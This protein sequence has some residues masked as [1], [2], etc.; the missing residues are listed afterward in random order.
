MTVP[1]QLKVMIVD[2]QQTTREISAVML[3]ANGYRVTTCTDCA[4][5]LQRLVSD[6]HDALLVNL[7]MPGM[8]RH[9]FLRALNDLPLERP[10]VKLGMASKMASDGVSLRPELGL[11]HVVWKPFRGSELRQALRAALANGD[12]LA[13]A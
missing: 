8:E 12:E 2:D 9:E 3:S 6:P 5:A 10:P 4:D 11:R 7:H 13:E 1:G